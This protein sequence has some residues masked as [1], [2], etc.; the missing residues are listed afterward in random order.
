MI[1]PIEIHTYN[2]HFKKEKIINSLNNIVEPYCLFGFSR[3]GKSYHG[4]I[5]DEGFSIRKFSLIKN[6]FRPNIIGEF[7]TENGNT[8]IKVIMCLHGL[9]FA[10]MAFLFIL[11]YL[12]FPLIIISE[13]IKEE[14]GIF[15][16]LIS[17][18]IIILVATVIFYGIM[19]IG[20]KIES[21]I[22][23]KYFKEL[24]CAEMYEEKNKKVLLR[25]IIYGAN[26]A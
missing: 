18:F 26:F 17:I 24:F 1:L 12:L 21:N 19:I 11:I 20:F 13:S 7:E 5:T 14:I 9:T 4:K 2:T 8:I 6:I 23:K 3:Y 22:T 16:T 25:N 15:I 10:F